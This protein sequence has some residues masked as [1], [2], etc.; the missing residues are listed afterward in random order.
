[1]IRVNDL[2]FGFMSSL[3]S[4]VVVAG[5]TRKAQSGALSLYAL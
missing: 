1:M 2:V 4:S 5:K 3:L